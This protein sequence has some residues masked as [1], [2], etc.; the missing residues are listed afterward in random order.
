MRH[1]TSKTI[2]TMALAMGF[3]LVT[4]AASF[5]ETAAADPKHRHRHK[6]PRCRTEYVVHVDPAVYRRRVY[7]APPAPP[8]HAC[9][10]YYDRACN[11]RFTSY[12][13]YLEHAR[14]HRHTQLVFVVQDDEPRS[15]QDSGWRGWV[16]VSW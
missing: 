13:V 9:G 10:Y 3:T 5:P 4:L 16:R 2:H 15:R 1:P 7:D 8:A 14:R 11:R 6:K 12:G